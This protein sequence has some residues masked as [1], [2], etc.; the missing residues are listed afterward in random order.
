MY[1]TYTCIHTLTH[2]MYMRTC[3][4]TKID[5][6]YQVKLTDQL[7]IWNSMLDDCT[8]HDKHT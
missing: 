5:M 3:N 2:I 6:Y 4:F 8:T 1:H 7:M